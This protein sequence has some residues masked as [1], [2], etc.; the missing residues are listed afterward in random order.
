MPELG[1]TVTRQSIAKELSGFNKQQ[2]MALSEKAG[3][4]IDGTVADLKAQLMPPTS[5]LIR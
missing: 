2:L 4:D 3:K 5:I 1:A